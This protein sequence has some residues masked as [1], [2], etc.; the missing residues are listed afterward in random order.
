MNST[1]SRT[2]PRLSRWKCATSPLAPL[3]VRFTSS[4]HDSD[5]NIYL[6]GFQGFHFS[7]VSIAYRTQCF[8]CPC[9]PSCPVLKICTQKH[10]L[11]PQF[12]S[13]ARQIIRNCGIR[14]LKGKIRWNSKWRNLNHVARWTCFCFATFTDGILL[15]LVPAV[16]KMYQGNCLGKRKWALVHCSSRAIRSAF[17]ALCDVCRTIYTSLRVERNYHLLWL[18]ITSIS[19]NYK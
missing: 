17:I 12:R 3:C 2:L 11:T 10:R 5:L 6:L 19:S 1:A 15:S 9:L 4:N 8:T 7:H 18:C 14:W 13:Y 16:F